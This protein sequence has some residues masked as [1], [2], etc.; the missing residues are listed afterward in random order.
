MVLESATLS[1]IN[2]VG[3]PARYDVEFAVNGLSICRLRH[4]LADV[5]ASLTAYK[6]RGLTCRRVL[7]TCVDGQKL[8][9]ELAGFVGPYEADITGVIRAREAVIDGHALILRSARF[10]ETA[11]VLS[12]F[13]NLRDVIWA[14]WS[15]GVRYRPEVT[16]GN[17]RIIQKG[18]RLPQRGAL[19]AV[20]SH[21]TLGSDPAIV[22]MP[23][24]TGKTEVMIAAAISAEANRVLVIVPTDA[25]R[26]QTGD[27]FLTY[28][29][30]QQIGVVADIPNPV[31]GLLSS[32]PDRAHIGPIRTCN[33]VVTTMSSIGLANSGLQEEFAA[34]FSHVFFDEAHHME[35]T[36]WKRFR[37][38]CA[39]AHTLLF[40]ATPF[41]EDGRAIE[42][43]II[44]NF[45]LS[46]AQQHGYFRPIR[47]VEVFEP[48]A[49]RSNDAIATAAVARLRA[50]L[51]AGHDHI[52]M[53]RTSKIDT[54]EAIFN[55]TYARSYSDLNPVLVH[56][57]TPGKRGVLEAIRSGRHR[58][59]VCVDMFGEGFDL[60]KLKIAAL[61]SVHKS[62][63]ITLQF[64]GRF[65]RA[66]ENVGQATFVANTAEDGVPEALEN[67]YREDADWNLMLP[68]LSY[69]AINPQEQLSALVANLKTVVTDE[70]AP[71]IST[72]AL[73]PKIS[74][75]VYRTTG[76]HPERY[77]D[78]FSSRQKIYQP[79]I[80][81]LDNFLILVVNQQE[82]LDWTDSRDI[83]TDS[84]DLYLAYFDPNRN[85]LYLHSSR[86]GNVTDG[87]AKA[88]S[89]GPVLVR[90]EE[91][92]KAFSKLKRLTLHSVGLSSRSK[93]VRYQMFAG[94][95]V[96][97]AIDP[98]LQQDKMK[99]NVTGVG[100][101]DG[102]RH[103]V[104]CSRKG[105]IWSMSSGSIARWKTWCDEIGTKLSNPDAQ[106][107]D[108]LRYTL[109]PSLI[110]Q[111]PEEAAL[112]IDWPDQLFEFSNFRFQVKTPE[113]SYDFH[114]CQL[115]LLEWV[116]RQSFRFIL[117]A[118][119]DIETTME[120]RIEAHVD[121]SVGSRESTYAVRHVSG[122][123][124]EIEAAGQR[125]KEQEFFEANPPLV[126]F[127]DGSQLSGNI[128][129]KPREGL[130]ETF[131]RNLIRTLDWAG[132][133][134]SKESR[135]RNG[136]I[137][138]DS[139]QHQ[140][141][142]HLEEGL[143]SFIIDDDD[144]GE[145]ADVVAIE[146][147]ADTIV[148]TLWHC[149]YAGGA[150]AGQRADDLYAVCGQAQKSVKWTWSFENLVKHLLIRETEHRRGRESRFIRGSSSALVT[151]RK[152]ARRKFVTFGVGIVQPG[153]SKANVPADHLAIIGATSSF[154]QCITDSPLVVY[155][156]P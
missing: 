7:A 126:R 116:D 26:Q 48:D 30:L 97:N 71:E 110:D 75:Q 87:L 85:L 13:A 14:G 109:I 113:T 92:F 91:T 28:G 117:R 46:A 102:K 77:A 19:H 12:D 51:A 88:I 69:D 40:T 81:Q 144:S 132:I 63:G 23:T 120:L 20:A 50:D 11:S 58:I 54:A 146:E 43:R 42:G 41:R 27:K 108:F 4:P 59:I 62:L 94:L 55:E 93:N 103:T 130:P 95:D 15:A 111:L 86:K 84:W 39:K 67:L 60:P 89:D 127:A 53:A 114:D 72:I 142:A 22:V 38:Y 70:S 16:D 74:A 25:L 131:E 150:T 123:R 133:D 137:R 153:L 149:K 139:I 90:G 36:T 156:S 45:P 35:A 135:W 151:L 154:I 34:L 44:Y 134:F 105:K 52:L 100:Y 8:V 143:A 73:K 148:V 18:L 112:M 96:R 49:R 57:R 31:V 56:S 106:P 82:S 29:L 140:F 141:I 121:D 115:D 122:P 138:R 68:D 128:L 47:F 125:W 98:I 104:G 37:Q 64:I 99:S 152:G 1:S 136:V 5:A 119:E 76:Y 147:T 83:A 2:S 33:V 101:E 145:S 78:A 24:G 21:W 107:D 32:K 129:L 79:R 10:R 66:A 61:H 118:G 3:I 80:S 65:A 17:G 155:G 124:V 9:I 6:S